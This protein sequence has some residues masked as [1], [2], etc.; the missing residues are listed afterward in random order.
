MGW[1]RHKGWGFDK[2]RSP[3]VGTFNYHQ[4]LGARTFES[5]DY[6]QHLVLEAVKHLVTSRL[7]VA[8]E[9]VL[10]TKDGGHCSHKDLWVFFIHM[11]KM[12]AEREHDVASAFILF[13][14]IQINTSVHLH[15]CFRKLDSYSVWLHD[16]NVS[17]E[18]ESK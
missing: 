9:G 8:L 18:F 14:L 11:C 6:G 2:G 17:P 15:Y 16:T 13:I 12:A 4:V 10:V 3:V 1:R 5:F 7:S